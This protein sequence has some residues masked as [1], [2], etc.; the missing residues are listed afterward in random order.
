[1]FGKA[2]AA[3]WELL[4]FDIKEGAVKRV[5]KRLNSMLSSED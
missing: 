4:G 1:M 5:L 3:K 2:L